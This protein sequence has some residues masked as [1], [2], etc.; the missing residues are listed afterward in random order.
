M[1]VTQQA[2]PIL[3]YADRLF[4]PL[5]QEGIFRS[6]DELLKSLLLDYIDRQIA[7]YEEQARAFEVK[8]EMT[9]EEYTHN[10]RGRASIA[11]EDEWMDWEE[12]LVFLRK[13]KKIKRQT[14]D[15]AS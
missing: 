11:E 7:L 12:A 15:A 2:T 6:Y 9:F 14:A 1:S 8:H 3:E 5:V 13:W 4:T 10:L